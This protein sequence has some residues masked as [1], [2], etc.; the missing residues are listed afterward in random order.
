[1]NRVNRIALVFFLVTFIIYNIPL[2]YNT[3]VTPFFHIIPSQDVVSNSLV[4][5]SIL[6]RGN[7][8]LDQ[9]R[10]Y[11]A[12][13]YTEQH[14]VYESNKH[15]VPLYPIEPGILPLPLMG[16]GIGIGWIQR[17]FNV[18]DVARVVAALLSS[19]AVVAFFY[20]ARMLT[21]NAT[22]ILIT[23]GF[24]F[25]SGV[26]S[27]ASSGMWQH[28]PS[29]MFQSM[30]FYFVLRGIKQGGTAL[31]PAGMF[32]S[33]AV[34]S[35]PSN[36]VTAAIFSLY[37]LIHH[38]RAIIPFLLWTIPPAI[39]ILWYN[40]AYHGSPLAFG[41]QDEATR[42]L[43]FPSME[44]LQGLLFAPSRGMFIFSPI[45]LLAPI[46]VWIGGWKERKI[47]Y[48]YLAASTIA[49]ALLMAMWG[50]LG[51]WAYGARML[52]D[53]LPAMFLL[54]IPV[55]EKIKGAWRGGLWAIVL[56]ATLMQALGIWDYGLR[57]DAA[58]NSV[59]SIENNEPLFYLRLYGE[60]IQEWLGM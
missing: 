14:F 20:C 18:F 11:I 27:T 29:I 55:V 2:A 21:D 57:F 8:Y 12:N 28:T 48:V 49:Y 53:I 3:F 50:S 24:A 42:I 19:L 58:N 32:F 31:A 43:A 4:S 59:W 37:V 17:T 1:M 47:I 51:G 13:N 54:I 45:L 41:Y 39:P 6:T 52:T 9:Y 15:L 40:W 33:L 60:M 46:G 10:N 7:F 36:I 34:L 30:A 16:W 22:S 56:L 35:R 26:W 38:R 5:M 44:A 23:F 25:G